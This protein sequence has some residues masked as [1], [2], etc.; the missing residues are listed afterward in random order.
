MS[1]TPDPYAALAE[2]EQAEAHYRLMFQTAPS[3][4][5][6]DVGRAWDRMRKAGDAARAALAQRAEPAGDFRPGWRWMTHPHWNRG[7]PMP[8]WCFHDEFDGTRMYAPMRIVDATS[9]EW[10][11]RDD[12]WRD[13]APQAQHVSGAA[14][15]VGSPAGEQ[16]G[17]VSAAPTYTPQAQ[18]EPL[19]DEQIDALRGLDTPQRVRFY[20]HDFYVLSNF[21]AFCL[22]WNGLRFDTSEAAYHYEKFPG[23][24][25][26]QVA[27]K[28]A[29]SAHEAFKI[30]ERWKPQRRS[31]WDAVKVG[32]MRDILRAKAK[33]HEYVTRKLLAT[34]DR[35]LVEDSWRDDFWGWGPNRDGQNMLGKVWME[36]R[37][38]LRMRGQS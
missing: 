34:G 25:A 24:P 21:S 18:P 20:E 6:L 32:I 10:E 16:T 11:Q 12:E 36:V 27:I 37:A 19:S 15:P 17:P 1:E 31:D 13:V 30:A 5:H 29:P 4:S 26:L 33:Q 35:E 9:L 7:E 38:E 28:N 8:V 3:E 23:Q 2:L 14:D 22:Y